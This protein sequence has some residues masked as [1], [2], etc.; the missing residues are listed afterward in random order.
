MVRTDADLFDDILALYG[1]IGALVNWRSINELTDLEGVQA[2]LD[3][4]GR[5]ISDIDG[6]LD[7]LRR[8]LGDDGFRAHPR[9]GQ[10]AAARDEAVGMDDSVIAKIKGKMDE[11]QND[12]KSRA[13]FKSRALPSYLKQK[14]AFSR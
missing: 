2:M 7:E 13:L 5:M 6:A 10:L 4:R 8:R 9:Y 3:E 12:L 11:I 14:L 1:R